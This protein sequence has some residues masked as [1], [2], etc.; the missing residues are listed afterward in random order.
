MTI[1]WDL[2]QDQEWISSAGDDRVLQTF[3]NDTDRDLTSAPAA[4]PTTKGGEFQT[5]VTED[6]EEGVRR[7]GVIVLVAAVVVVAFVGWRFCE[8]WKMRRE[9]Y[10]LQVESS[11][12]DAVLGDMQM[13]PNADDEY[14][15]DDPELL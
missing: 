2:H 5:E 4:S 13:V 1:Y 3:N 10:M 9:R 12:A 8:R 15:E 6:E 11:R 7:F 14:D